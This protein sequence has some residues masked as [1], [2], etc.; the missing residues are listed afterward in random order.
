MSRLIDADPLMEQMKDCRNCAKWEDCPCGKK[1]HGNGFSIGYSAEECTEYKPMAKPCPFCGGEAKI[2]QLDLEDEGGISNGM[3]A[4]GCD[5]I[6]GSL[7][8]GYI[9]KCSPVYVSKELAVAMWNHRKEMSAQDGIN[10]YIYPVYNA[11]YEIVRYELYSDNCTK[12]I[13]KWD[14]V[15]NIIVKEENE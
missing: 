7:C 12:P 14:Y 6:N 8:P 13:R 9:Y 10:L 3:W 1:G 11:N 2:I 4:I 5:G 15:G